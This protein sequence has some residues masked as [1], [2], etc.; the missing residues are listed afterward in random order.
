MK[1]ETFIQGK[2]I[3]LILLDENI[4]K[5][6]DWYSW[7]N[8]QE[9]TKILEVGKFPNTLKKQLHYVRNELATKKQILS[10]QEVDKKI[11]L[12][13]VE[14]KNNTLVGMVSAYNI[15][16]ISRTCNVSVITDLRKKNIN[17]LQVFKECQDLLLDHL[18]FKLNLRKIYTGATDKKLS[19]MT[20]KIW[21]FKREA[22]FAKHAYIDGKYEDTFILGLFK[23]DWEKIRG[24]K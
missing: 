24:K 17:R 7:L 2:Y 15:N 20:M 4:A 14:K 11:Q 23:I 10:F 1:F 12:G 22:V 13:V 5:K 9:N 6:T 18:F 3:D 8:H 19:D 16:Y 21:G